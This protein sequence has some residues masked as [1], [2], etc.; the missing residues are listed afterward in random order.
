M[1]QKCRLTII[2]N[3]IRL[4]DAFDKTRES[5]KRLDSILY[6]YARAGHPFRKTAAQLKRQF[7]TIDKQLAEKLKNGERYL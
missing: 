3:R 5:L 6:H 2:T 4:K 1:P 7:D